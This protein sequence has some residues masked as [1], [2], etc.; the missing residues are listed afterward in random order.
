M[1]DAL[2]ALSF[3]LPLVLPPATAKPEMSFAPEIAA[4][5]HKAE[6][7][8]PIC[9]MARPVLAA[10][11]SGSIQDVI[12][13]I[14]FD[15]SAPC[16]VDP[17]SFVSPEA[18]R[19]ALPKCAAFV[20]AQPPGSSAL[21]AAL[22]K[23]GLLQFI[24][25]DFG[26]RDQDLARATLD[27]ALAID[28]D[29]LTAL[30]SKVMF[31]QMLEGTSAARADIEHLNT[32]Y[33]DDPRVRI[34][35]AQLVADA[36]TPEQAVTAYD[37]ALEVASDNAM[38]HQSRA[39]RLAALGRT[40]EALSE[41]D[42]TIDARPSDAYSLF[43]RA[44]LHFARGDA[45]AALV[46]A[47]NARTNGYPVREVTSLIVQANL[48]LGNLDQALTEI[49]QLELDPLHEDPVLTFYRFAILYRLDRMKEAEDALAAF[50]RARPEYILRVQV[51]LR[52]MGFEA[53]QIS[54]TPDEATQ[55]QLV[56]CLLKGACSSTIQ[57]VL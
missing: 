38:L 57:R 53:V 7:V 8:V 43:E 9:D 32:L 56:A 28:P 17:P 21:A 27:M 47:E 15:A 13:A 48:V 55:Q 5:V 52:N 1:N 46:D 35:H 40:P 11:N 49:T 34:Y 3:V 16:P 33:P 26:A 4:C 42:L 36:G 29:D 24:A 45:K 23:Q 50:A 41:L 10:A 44:K 22:G 2:I 19:A 54:G 30:L 37:S 6:V 14:P 25:G 12:A 20:A 39:E 31:L 18:S 51:F